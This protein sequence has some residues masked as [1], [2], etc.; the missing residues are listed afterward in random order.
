MALL[1]GVL[2]CAVGGMSF[3]RNMHACLAKRFPEQRL[4]PAGGEVGRR[5]ARWFCPGCGV[6]LDREMQCK[7]CGRSIRDQL[8]HLVEL[9]PHGYESFRNPRFVVAVSG[10]SR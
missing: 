10:G 5:L 4:R 3:S 6:P 9:H 8:F 1:D 2:T 7:Q